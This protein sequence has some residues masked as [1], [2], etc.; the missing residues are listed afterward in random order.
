MHEHSTPTDGAGTWYA[1]I[2]DRWERL[3]WVERDGAATPLRPCGDELI[4]GF[5]WGG[6]GIAVRELARSILA[7]ATGNPMLAELRCREFAWEV[8]AHL[9]AAEFRLSREDVLLWLEAADF[10][11]AE[12][13]LAAA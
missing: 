6:H 12:P 8:V 1:G 3:V 10:P 4:A 7:D 5:R 13:A 9:P 2:S 11:P